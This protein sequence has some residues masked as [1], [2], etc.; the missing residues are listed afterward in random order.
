[1]HERHEKKKSGEEMG[2][3]RPWASGVLSKLFYNID[4]LTLH[5]MEKTK[6]KNGLT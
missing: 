3:T 2:S 6:W 4:N 5:T 1:M